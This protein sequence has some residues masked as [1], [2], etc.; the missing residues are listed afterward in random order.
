MLKSLTKL[1]VETLF[2][3]QNL[4]F[5]LRRFDFGGMK[6]LFQQ[7]RAFFDAFFP[8]IQLRLLVQPILQRVVLMVDLL[9]LIRPLQPDLLNLFINNSHG[10]LID[11]EPRV[12]LRL[13]LYFRGSNAFIF[14]QKLAN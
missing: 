2:H 3:L 8:F 9:V 14:V 5:L 11:D 7:K 13:I 1:F 10:F 12:M 6:D 4:E